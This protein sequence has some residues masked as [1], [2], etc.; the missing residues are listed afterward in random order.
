MI[1]Y[2][3]NKEVRLNRSKDYYENSKGR[4]RDQAKEKYRKRRRKQKDRIWKK[5]IS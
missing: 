2:Q 4:L 3:K 5:Q 1:Y